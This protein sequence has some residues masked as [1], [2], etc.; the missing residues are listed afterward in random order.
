[1]IQDN[2]NI[3]SE[4]LTS[5]KL[6]LSDINSKIYSNDLSIKEERTCVKSFEDND[7][8]DLEIFYPRKDKTLLQK[9]EMEKANTRILEYEEQNRRLYH[10]KA[11]L[12]RKIRQLEQVLKLERDNLTIS[13]VQE[14]DRQRI[15]R[16]L[17]D[18]SLQ[19]L[20]HLVHKIEL[21]NLYIDH[22]PV[23]A[24]EELLQVST[25]LKEVM[26]EV[27]NI[28]FDLRPMCFDDLGLKESLEHL[29]EMLNENEKYEIISDIDDVLCENNF[30]LVYIY[31][32][33]QESLNNIVKH[34]DASKIILRCKVI[35]RICVIDIED[36]GKGFFDEHEEVKDEHKHFGLS[37][38][39]ERV[40]L[41]NGKIDISSFK[42]EGTKIHIEIPLAG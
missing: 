24:K 20:V 27:R 7:T 30:I 28:I 1:M 8:D 4:I 34:A 33:V 2:Y 14:E 36:N 3:L 26:N 15:A 13:N 25:S 22:D 29:L 16:D 12:E 11:V 40:E 21:C 18:I 10:D 39:R 9:E 19:N 38:M 5:F 31:R 41:L 23:K 32:T 35:E 17:H 37:L 42:G 6:E